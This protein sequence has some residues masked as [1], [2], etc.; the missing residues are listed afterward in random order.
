M[1]RQQL[2]HDA[3]MAHQKL[4]ERDRMEGVANAMNGTSATG[5][6]HKSFYSEN[7]QGA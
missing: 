1:E 4:G 7:T 2:R 3:R 5:F 6:G